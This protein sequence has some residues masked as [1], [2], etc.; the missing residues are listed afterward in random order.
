MK[1]AFVTVFAAALLPALAPAQK[2]ELKLDAIAAQASEKNEVDLDG[3]ILAAALKAARNGVAKDFKGLPEGIKEV[4]VRNYEFARDGA[5]KQQDL[6]PLR[7]QLGEKSGWVRIVN[8]KES[9]ETT[10]VYLHHKTGEIGGLLV[11][12]AEARELTV[13]HIAGSIPEDK[14]SELVSSSVH[15]DLAKL[16]S[17]GQE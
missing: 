9:H 10:E 16:V 17:S 8:V 5:Y 7:R 1:I 13:L 6:E 4:H 3:A 12:A 2:L 14:L 15:F 11:L